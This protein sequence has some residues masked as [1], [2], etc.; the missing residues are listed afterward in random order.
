MCVQMGTNNNM[1]KC[2]INNLAWWGSMGS[3]SW[4]DLMKILLFVFKI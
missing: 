3:W 4:D 2:G 1:I